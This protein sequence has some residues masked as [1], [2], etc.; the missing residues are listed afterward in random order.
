[1]AP[2]VGNGPLFT[3]CMFAGSVIAM[4]HGA[5]AYVT[6]VVAIVLE[7]LVCVA[8]ARAV[9]AANVRLLTSRKGR[10]LALL[11]GLVIAVGAQLYNFGANWNVVPMLAEAMPKD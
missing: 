10:D 9:A 7:L 2:L 4:A 8:L 6:G 11:S 3:L 5:A 1:M